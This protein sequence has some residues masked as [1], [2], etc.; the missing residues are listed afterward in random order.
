MIVPAYNRADL[1][2]QC[3]LS[4]RDLDDVE[5]VLVDNGS[6][7][8]TPA[9]YSLADEVVRFRHNEGFAKGC[10]AG[11][12]RAHR[13]LLVFLNNDTIPQAGWLEPLVDTLDTVAC[14]G[15]LLVYP[16]GTVQH[17]GVRLQEVNGVLTAFNIGRGQP[18]TPDLLEPRDVDA[19][20]GACMAVR[21]KAFWH[22]QGF[23]ERYWNGYEDVDLCLK[24]R[25]RGY[26]IRYVPQSRV[27]HLESE[28]GPERW[29]AVQANVARLQERWG[30]R[31]QQ[32][33]ATSSP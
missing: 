17:A 6:T 32:I 11:A 3:L 30:D 29:T 9:L 2:E 24:L 18:L 26:R 21:A 13:D 7:D 15:S 14:A 1:T 10:N 12:D 27:V 31:W 16:D 4:L 28:S 19:V 20:T 22:A 25:D 8:R 5:I 23:D 33:A